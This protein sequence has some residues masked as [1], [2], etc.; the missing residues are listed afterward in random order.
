MRRASVRSVY[1]PTSLEPAPGSIVPALYAIARSSTHR[2][3]A[4]PLVH[5]NS[6]PSLYRRNLPLSS[7]GVKP[8]SLSEVPVSEA[9]PH[10][11]LEETF[12]QASAAPGRLQRLQHT[13]KSTNKEMTMGLIHGCPTR[14]N[15]AP[16]LDT[17]ASACLSQFMKT[18]VLFRTL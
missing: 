3:E 11:V 18:L 15:V 8:L 17:T 6:R 12:D 16:L 2:G 13:A 14:T 10:C 4:R 9:W 5:S 1:V 7:D